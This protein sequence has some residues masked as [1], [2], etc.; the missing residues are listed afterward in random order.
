LVFFSFFSPPFAL[1]P[2]V[3]KAEAAKAAYAKLVGK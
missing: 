3:A 2:F 1:Q